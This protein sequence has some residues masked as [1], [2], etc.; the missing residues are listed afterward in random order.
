MTN[1]PI[2]HA[3]PPDW[4]W[5]FDRKHSR[6]TNRLASPPKNTVGQ[7]RHHFSINNHYEY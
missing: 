5:L 2:H 7:A 4:R 1:R 3:F 6:H